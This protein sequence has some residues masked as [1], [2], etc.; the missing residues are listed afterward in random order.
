MF[1]TCSTAYVEKL[2]VFGEIRVSNFFR[3]PLQ[4]LYNRARLKGRLEV[5]FRFRVEAG[6]LNSPLAS[7]AML[8]VFPLNLA[9]CVTC[10]SA[11]S[12]STVPFPYGTVAKWC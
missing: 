3:E 9:I 1:D 2:T 11:L 8:R 4:S 10:M 6:R 7:P 5:S 12:V